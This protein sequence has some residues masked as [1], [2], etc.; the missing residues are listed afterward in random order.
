MHDACIAFDAEH[1]K[2]R[3]CHAGD[4]RHGCVGKS[5]HRRPLF[6]GKPK[7]VEEDFIKK[8]AS[9]LVCAISHTVQDVTNFIFACVNE[10]FAID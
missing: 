3:M 9:I 7:L 10:D 5:D 6:C 1:F 4:M 2:H 8:A